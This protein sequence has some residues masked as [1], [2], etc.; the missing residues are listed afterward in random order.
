M[1]NVFCFSSRS[2][3]DVCQNLALFI[4]QCK[5]ELSVFGADLD[6]DAWLWPRAAN[7]TK[8]GSV[9]RSFSIEDRMAEPFISF[10]KA[11]FRYQQGHRPTRS[12]NESKA[13]KVLE[14]VLTD[15]HGKP[16]ILDLDASVLDRAAL[17]AREHYKSAAYHCGRELQRLAKFVSNNLLVRNSCDTW[18]NPISRPQDSNKV[19]KKA[20]EARARK[21][22]S[23]EAVLAMA[24]IF[25][26][27]GE[28]PRDIFT[29]S[30]F[31]LL[32]SGSVRISEVLHLPVDCEVNDVTRE[33][34][35]VYGIRFYSGKGYG[36]NI[37]WVPTVMWPIV[38]EALARIRKL[39]DESRQLSRWLEDHPDLMFIHPDSGHLNRSK[40]L[41]EVEACEALGLYLSHDEAKQRIYYLYGFSKGDVLTLET[42]WT[43]FKRRMPADF[44]SVEP[45]AGVTFGNALFAMQKNILTSQKG[46]LRV[47]PWLPEPNIVNN[48]L[49]PRLSLGPGAHNSIF[50]RYNFAHSDGTEMKIT[51]HQMRHM[52]DTMGHRGGMSEEEIAR[53]AG[54]ADQKQNRVYNHLTSNE[55][56][57]KYEQAQI[58]AGYE[59][60]IMIHCEPVGRDAYD[61]APKGPIHR[62]LW[63]FCLHD[64]A[65]APCGMFRDCLNC[66][67]HLCEK[68]AGTKEEL[69]AQLAETDEQLIATELAMSAGQYGADR[70]Y[71]HHEVSA[72]RLRELIAIMDD[73]EVPDGSLI[74]LRRDHSP[75]HINRAL[76]TRGEINTQSVSEEKINRLG[77]LLEQM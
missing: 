27:V 18:Q 69:A 34:E 59:N 24:D 6:F 30:V 40:P 22:P 68:R 49:S 13:L 29:S 51:T 39:T 56:A 60:S 10:A 23:S 33:G 77:N 28:D 45:R 4:D 70:W 76:R 71:E 55:I 63:G 11:Y 58:A 12:R 25:A 1:N 26:N 75:S 66:E 74:R 5:G 38:K 31:A 9:S 32:M 72:S 19:G 48:D 16:D 8:L 42:L 14:R 41:T 46:T 54:R 2:E 64:Y 67:E 20:R 61:L 17:L 52:I 62:S 15:A 43:K 21:L 73:D 53:F 57:V 35:K 37:K 50:S 3:I 44:P 65:A 7:F 47:I 36:A